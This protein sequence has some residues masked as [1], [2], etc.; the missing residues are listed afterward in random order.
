MDRRKKATVSE[1]IKVSGAEGQWWPGVG[2][3]RGCSVPRSSQGV[4]SRGA[5]CQGQ[6]RGLQDWTARR[7]WEDQVARLETERRKMI[8]VSE[9]IKVSKGSQG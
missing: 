2:C 9:T 5:Q 7:R 1:T 6:Q 8:K 4:E 3:G